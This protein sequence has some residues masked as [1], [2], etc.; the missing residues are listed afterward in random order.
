MKK[1]FLDRWIEE[2]QYW[3]FAIAIF[4][5]LILI[6]VGGSILQKLWILFHL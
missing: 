3:K 4:I 2:G 5:M 1:F 6:E